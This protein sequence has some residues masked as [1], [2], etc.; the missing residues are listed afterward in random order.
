MN[1]NTGF[2]KDFPS[3]QRGEG[4]FV[5]GAVQMRVRGSIIP[6]KN[7]SL[8]TFHFSRKRAATRII[9]GVGGVTFPSPLEGEG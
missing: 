1:K 3:P 2:T 5:G 9:R 6:D 8:L 4:A 7:F